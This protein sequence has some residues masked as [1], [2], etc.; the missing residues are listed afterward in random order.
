[1]LTLLP[2]LTKRYKSADF[3][4]SASLSLR[5]PLVAAE[6]PFKKKFFALESA[7]PGAPHQTGGPLPPG[8]LVRW[9][10][11]SYFKLFTLYDV[12]A[13]VL[14]PQ[15]HR[16]CIKNELMLADLALFVNHKMLYVFSILDAMSPWGRR[17]RTLGIRAH[18]GVDQSTGEGST[19]AM[20]FASPPGVSAA[21]PATLDAIAAQIGR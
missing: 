10:Y 13:Q 3:H 9:P 16:N 20:G 14:D 5:A 15:G 19:R 1:M 11:E 17:P 18:S 8:S 21:I 7:R 6:S 12:M 4:K 2:Q